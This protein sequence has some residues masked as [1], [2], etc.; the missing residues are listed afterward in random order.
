MRLI[1]IIWS[2]VSPTPIDIDALR[3]MSEHYLTVET[4]KKQLVAAR[5]AGFTYDVPA[6]LLIGVARVESSYDPSSTSR[7]VNGVRT[8]GMWPSRRPGKGFSGPYFCGNL[9]TMAGMSWRRCLAM[10]DPAVG[11]MAGAQEIAS[12]LKRSRGDVA[13]ALA[14]HCCGNAGFEARRHGRATVANRYVRKV[15]RA[16]A[17]FNAYKKDGPPDRVLTLKR[18]PG[19]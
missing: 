7:L 14:G 13:L 16:R 12:W 10:R 19:V 2:V 17:Q 9:Q 4:A 15:R 8:T 1:Y 11:Y 3:Q 6:D 5:V 18:R